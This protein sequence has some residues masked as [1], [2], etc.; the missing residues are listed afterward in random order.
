MTINKEQDQ[1]QIIKDDEIDLI[2]LVKTIWNG[3]KTI[4][5]SVGIAVFIGL[6]I[7][8][9]SPA[10]YRAYCTLIPSE[11]K[12]GGSLGNLGAIAGMAGINIGSM[13][14]GTSGIPAEIYPQVV[15]SYPFKKEMVHQKF[16][17]TEYVE[18]VSLYEYAVADTLE[19]FGSKVIKYTILL[20]WTIKD[21][22]LFKDEKELDLPDYGV[23][24]LSEEELLAMAAVEEVIVVEVDKKTGL[25]NV[26]AEVGEPVLVAQ[27]VQKAVELLQDYIIKYK[28]KQAREHLEFVQGQYNDK[29][30]QYEF[31]QSSF[32]NYKDKHRNMVTERVDLEFQRLSDEYDMAS[33][34]YK[35]LAQQ[36]EQAKI[37][38]NEQ[39]P[40][41]T[42]LEPAKVPIEKSAPNKKVI[43]VVS[44][45]LGSFIGIGVIFGRLILNNLKQSL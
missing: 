2:A 38:V 6:L 33:T 40:A 15:N 9:T 11:E 28:T 39:T 14:G 42:I 26:S 27:L 45:I 35:G 25:I 43:I 12:Q 8:F 10:K 34:I 44:I 1:L 23:L 16:H 37:T 32:Y 19:T 3:R 7:A 4:Y 20:P 36:L 24:N 41:F 22:L 31:A 17:F 18:P 21:A 30:K 5:Y 13:M 29:K